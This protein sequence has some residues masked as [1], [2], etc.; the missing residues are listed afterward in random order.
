M[1]LPDHVLSGDSMK[2]THVVLS[3]PRAVGK[4]TIGPAVANRLGMTFIDLDV[5]V[6]N[7]FSESTVAA[8]WTTHGESAW[9]EMETTVLADLLNEPPMVLALGGGVPTIPEAAE[10]LN[11]SRREGSAMVI[12][13]QADPHELASRLETC[14]DDRPSLTGSTPAEEIIEICRIRASSYEAV[15]DVSLDVGM[16]EESQAVDSVLDLIMRQQPSN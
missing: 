15:S 3:G 9:R 7:R 11:R 1:V 2:S 12:W 10:S 5:E 14:S 13:L 4:S 16:M 6:L 8:V